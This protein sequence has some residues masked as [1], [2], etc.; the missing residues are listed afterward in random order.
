MKEYLEKEPCLKVSMV[1]TDRYYDNLAWMYRARYIF[2]DVKINGAHFIAIMPKEDVGLRHLI[3]NQKLM[4]R[5]FNLKCAIFMDFTSYYRRKRLKEEGIPFVVKGVQIYLPFMCIVLTSGKEKIIPPVSMISFLAQKMVLTAIYEKWQNVT[6]AQAAK[7]LGVA[8]MSAN[9]C[10]DEI[11]YLGIKIL[12][13]K[14]ESRVISIPKDIEKLWEEVKEKLRS[15]VI[16]TYALS[17]D[18]KLDKLGGISALCEY[19]LLQD[20]DYPT[21]VI[22]KKDIVKSGIREMEPVYFGEEIGSLVLEVGYFINFDNN[23]VEDPFSVILSLSQ[24]DLDDPRVDL[25]I[26]EMLKENVWFTD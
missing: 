2:Y 3:A 6:A 10:F 24:E 12:D 8:R 20:N 23:N 21:Y 17:K 26:K 19:S 1:E 16:K 15:P 25:S 4:E 18:I 22:T 9:R 7:K 11:Q 14:G 5:K 13:I